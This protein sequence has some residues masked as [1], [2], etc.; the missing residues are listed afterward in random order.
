MSNRFLLVLWIAAFALIAPFATHAMKVQYAAERDDPFFT[1][2]DPATGAEAFPSFIE[3]GG[4]VSRGLTAAAANPVTGEVFLVLD[5]DETFHRLVTVNPRTGIATDIGNIG[6]LITGLAFDAAGTLYGVTSDTNT[7]TPDTIFTINTVTAVPTF[8]M[9]VPT[10]GFG[11][12]DTLAFNPD[13]GQL[14]H[15]SGSDTAFFTAI[16]LSTQN[17]TAIT[18]SGDRPIG[19]GV[20]A[21]TYD[22]DQGLFV[23]YREDEF[24]AGPE[25][26]TITAGGFQTYLSDA[27]NAQAGMVFYDTDLLPPVPDPAAGRQ[28]YSVDTFGPYVTSV[29]PATGLDTGVTAIVSPDFVVSGGNGLAVDPNT[30][31]FYAAAKAITGG[32]R[33][34]TLDPVTGTANLIGSLQQ[35]VAGLAFDDQGVLYAVSGEG[36]AMPETLFTVDKTTALMTEVQVLSD[37]DGGEAIAFNTSDGLMYR[38]SGWITPIFEKIDLSNNMVTDIPLSGDVASRDEVTGLTYDTE[39]NIFLGSK[40]TASSLAYFSFTPG[41]VATNLTVVTLTGPDLVPKKGLAFS[42]VLPTDTDGDGVLDADDNCP[43]VANADQLDFDSDGAGDVCDDDDDNDGV[44][45]AQDALPMAFLD[46]PNTNF[47]YDFIETLALSGVTG[48]CG[49]GNYCPDD[50]VTRAQMAVFLERGMRGSGYSPPAASGTVFGDVGAGDFAAAW[51]EQLFADGIT[52]GCGGGNYCPNDSVTRA[53]MAVFLLRAKFGSGYAPPP[54]TGVFPDAPLGSFAVDWV[55]A[56]AAE[57]ISGGCGGG[58]FC[59][60]DPVTRAQMAVFL[61]RA[62]EL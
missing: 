32:R 23:G 31:T 13:D 60:S 52:G 25:Y 6:E 29:D 24:G 3:V 57:G 30:G 1:Q 20:L 56:L 16:N 5:T 27:P 38:A 62:F 26:F 17:T 33:L 9:A 7:G 15:W 35:A 46:V 11:S 10:E 55:E 53:Q 12:G 37:D 40:W 54:A 44:P 39:Q 41:G 51:I 50:S 49:G 61:V 58:N 59:P 48:G 42:V 8:F 18:L 47:A 19:A 43:S 14:Y 36:G 2:I 34:V 22:T 4:F 28:L 45:D 21:L